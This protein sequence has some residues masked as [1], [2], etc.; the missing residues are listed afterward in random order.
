MNP[1]PLVHC[2]L[3]RPQVTLLSA[4]ARHGIHMSGRISRTRSICSGRRT[5][6]GPNVA[7]GVPFTRPLGYRLVTNCHVNLMSCRSPAPGWSRGPDKDAA[8]R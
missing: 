4:D 2:H 5:R 3:R 8:I 1:P 6:Y 7:M